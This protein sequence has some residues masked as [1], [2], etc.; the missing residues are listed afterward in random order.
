MDYFRRAV[1]LDPTYAV[2]YAGIAAAYFRL[3]TTYLPPQEAFPKSKAAAMK[4]L[5][6]DD[7]LSEA[8]A[9]LGIVKM[10]CDWDWDSARQELERA[11]EISPEYA[12]GHQWY[13]V[14]LDSIGEFEEALREKRR[15]LKLDPLSLSINVSIG[16]TFWM[17]R[18][19]G[20]AL[21]SAYEVLEMDKNFPTAHLLLGVT[22]EL[23]GTSSQSIANMERAC[24]IDDTPIFQAYLGRAYA[25][26]GLDDKATTIIDDLIAQSARRYF[27][28][29][30][31]AL[32]QDG[33]G[34][35]EVTFDWLEKAYRDRDEFLCWLKVDPR[36]EHL[37]SDERF[38]DLLRRIFSNQA[39]KV[40]AEIS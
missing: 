6:L 3:A 38:K 34:A 36:F 26:S 8:H 16:T 33:L 2:A 5:E 10:R 39:V 27:S 4:A 18:Q 23:A 30:G 29:Y 21:R 13:G 17:M 20:E 25:L 1:Q 24:E 28:A 19:T 15:A 35:T 11:L 40:S 9:T 12:T 22:S 31:I 14:Y 32:I 7:R 37:R